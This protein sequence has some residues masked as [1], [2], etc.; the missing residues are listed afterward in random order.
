[1]LELR[2]MI[3]EDDDLLREWLERILTREVRD[4]KSYALPSLA[5]DDLERFKPDIVLTDIKMPEMNG[6]EMAEIIRASFPN[7]PVIV[8]S[9]F[10]EPDLFKTAIKLKVENFV[11]KPI[12]I[13][14]LLQTLNNVADH[15]DTKKQLREKE[16]L[17][18]QYKHIVDLSANI[19]ITDKKGVITYVNDRFC[20]LSGFSRDELIGHRHKMMRHPDMTKEFYKGLWDRI[21]DKQVWQG[22]IKNYHKNGGSFYGDTTISPILD[23]QGEIVEFIAIKNNITD[24]ITSQKKLQADIITDRLTRLSNRIKLQDDFHFYNDYTMMLIDIDHFKD[25]N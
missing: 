16:S 18:E 10:S 3:V 4:V 25:V 8:A 19:V 14:E 22:I 2:L 13:D 5:L 15:L 11:V 21:L 17:L 9:A 20:E 24:L 23:A 7:I 12:D 6:L 1:M